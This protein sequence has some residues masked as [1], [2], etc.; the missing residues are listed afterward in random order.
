MRGE[1][2]GCG[3]L[4]GLGR[5]VAPRPSFIFLFCPFY[6]SVFQF[7][8]NFFKIAPNQTKSK[9]SK[10]QTKTARKKFS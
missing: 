4:F 5:K 8:Y 2:L 3:R 10:Q 1:E 6:F 9:N 7:F